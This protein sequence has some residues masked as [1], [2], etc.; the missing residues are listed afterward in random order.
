MNSANVVS[1]PDGHRMSAMSAALRAPCTCCCTGASAIAFRG[2]AKARPAPA[3]QARARHRVLSRHLHV[4]C[5]DSDYGAQAPCNGWHLHCNCAA[6]VPL[7]VAM[8]HAA[9]AKPETDSGVDTKGAE[10][11]G[12]NRNPAASHTLLRERASRCHRASDRAA[13]RHHYNC[14]GLHNV[15]GGGHI[16][17]IRL[18]RRGL[19]L[20]QLLAVPGTCFR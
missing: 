1:I 8:R 2:E 15:W 20:I 13:C 17:K 9:P 14:G 18:R 11:D 5:H 3:W 6:S 16:T 12:I 7:H 4:Y 10:T 19:M